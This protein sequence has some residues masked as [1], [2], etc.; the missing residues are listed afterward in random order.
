MAILLDT[1]MF[2]LF[3]KKRAKN[4]QQWEY[5]LLKSVAEKLPSK[6][7]F[8][9]SQVNPN[10]ILDS[11]PNEFLEHG[12]KRIICDQNVYNSIKNN[13][14]NYK[15]VGIK[16]FDLEAKD[17]KN[18]E[19]DLYEGVLIGYKVDDSSRQFD[20]EN[21]DIKSLRK[22]PYENKEKEELEKIIGTVSN[23]ILAQLD[24][25]D[26]FKI[27]V[28][29]GEFYVI[30]DLEDGNYLSMN[31]KGAVYGMIHD[32]YEVEKLFE[33]KESFFEALKSGEFSISEYYDKKMS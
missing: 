32:P 9:I 2:N 25:D 14:I 19:L 7:S 21:I 17:Y 4:I 31:E 3:K 8:L 23:D 11:V 18:V 30:Q 24:I 33:T 6:Y 12:W 26:T 28:P 1:N 10:F 29:E 27:E 22:K 15:L 13:S 5:D 20:Y 16:V